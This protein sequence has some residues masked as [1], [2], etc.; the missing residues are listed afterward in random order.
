MFGWSEIVRLSDLIGKPADDRSERITPMRFAN[1]VTLN[2]RGERVVVRMRWGLVPPWET[3]PNNG[4]KHIHARAETIE[5]KK[6]FRDAFENRRGILIVK[7][8]NEGKE[9]TPTKTEQYTLAA[10]DGEPMG[11][12]VIWERWAD[13]AGPELLTFAMV[14]TEPTELIGT[15][16][17]RM[18]AEVPE[19][20][21]PRWLG[22]EPATTDELKA[23]L[24][25]SRRGM[26]MEK[27][28]KP[29]KPKPPKPA[30]TTDQTSLF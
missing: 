27:E 25:P 16:T 24:R 9:I 20:N 18:V 7:T 8:F 29:K 19:S 22:E 4:T 30:P 23:T 1:V 11:I 17:D 21:W 5:T 14:T 10:L 13:P 28:V 6:T 26:R 2:D 15:I 3:N 12:A